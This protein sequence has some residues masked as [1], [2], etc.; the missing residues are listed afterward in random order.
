MLQEDRGANMKYLFSQILLILRPSILQVYFEG[1]E[2]DLP[3]FS[4]VYCIYIYIF[5]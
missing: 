5:F 4:Y 3:S 2:E 1:E